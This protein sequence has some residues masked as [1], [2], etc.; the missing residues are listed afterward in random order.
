MS[1]KENEDSPEDF[2]NIY[3]FDSAFDVFKVTRR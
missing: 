3:D 2:K 1:G